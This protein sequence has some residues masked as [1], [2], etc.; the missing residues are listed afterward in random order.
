TLGVN[1]ML[2]RDF[3]A[4]EVRRGEEVAIIS[5]R[6]WTTQLGSDPQILEKELR[7]RGQSF[8]VIGILPP[9]FLDPMSLGTRDLHVALVVSK[10]E[11][12]S[13]NSKWLQVIG[14]VSPGGTISQAAVQVEALSERAQKEMGGR[15][16]RNMAAFTLTSLREFHVGNSK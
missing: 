2:G 6:L 12:G 9:E 13:R 1:P 16:P 8:R 10:E 3:L 11:A 14:R 4:D 7:L 15:D 5:H